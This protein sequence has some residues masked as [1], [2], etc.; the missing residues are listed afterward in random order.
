MNSE[1]LKKKL[2]VCN[3]Y[4]ITMFGKSFKDINLLQKR[5]LGSKQVILK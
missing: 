1:N 4:V 3:K 2:A 5:P